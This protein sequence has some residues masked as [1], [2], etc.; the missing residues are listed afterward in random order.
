MET[1]QLGDEL[2]SV[3][4]LNASQLTA[5]DITTLSQTDTPS[6]YESGDAMTPRHAASTARHAAAAAAA[7][8]G[9]EAGAGGRRGSAAQQRSNPTTSFLVGE[10]RGSV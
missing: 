8:A 9:D 3:T 2:A 4:M 6:P 7:A 5:A 10:T 1:F